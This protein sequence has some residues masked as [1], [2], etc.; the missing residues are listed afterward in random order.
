[1]SEKWWRSKTLF[2]LAFGAQ[3]FVLFL[4]AQWG[5]N[6]GWTALGLSAALL[7]VMIVGA[8]LRAYTIDYF[9]ARAHQREK[10]QR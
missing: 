9:A 3:M 4:V 5:S 2:W 6:R 8:I 10:S 1:M 7:P